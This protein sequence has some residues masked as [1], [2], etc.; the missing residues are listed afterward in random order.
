MM[1]ISEKVA[2]FFEKNHS[3]LFRSRPKTK[4]PAHFW[5]PAWLAAGETA[6][7][8]KNYLWRNF[9]IRSVFFDDVKVQRTWIA[10][11]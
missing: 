11:G 9:C 5:C 3:S 8:T 2:V 10:D 7:A 6:L 4:K 1:R